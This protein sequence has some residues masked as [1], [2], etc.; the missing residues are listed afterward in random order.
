MAIHS[1]IA[2]LTRTWAHRS[3]LSFEGG[4]LAYDGCC[5]TFAA[6]TLVWSVSSE[7]RERQ[8]NVGGYAA[9][10]RGLLHRVEAK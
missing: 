3:A 4:R 5:M 1:T 6:V 8:H 2:M 7:R 10:G 9:S